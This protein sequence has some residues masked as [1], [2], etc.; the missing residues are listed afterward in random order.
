M[1]MMNIFHIISPIIDQIIYATTES[2]LQAIF[3]IF[4][5]Y[6][7]NVQKETERFWSIICFIYLRRVSL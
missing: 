3:P 4:Q 5:I 6:I 1:T 7:I 2:M